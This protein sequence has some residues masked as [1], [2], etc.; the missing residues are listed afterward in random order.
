I[1]L[2]AKRARKFKEMES[3]RIVLVISG[4]NST[5]LLQKALQV[6]PW[7]CIRINAK[8][9]YEHPGETVAAFETVKSRQG[10]TIMDEIQ[11]RT[12]LII[13]TQLQVDGVQ[14]PVFGK[15]MFLLEQ[16]SSTRGL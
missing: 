10:I 15:T 16:Q 13:A 7:K 1:D 6:Y 11:S 12:G 8:F 2:I 5:E 3:C 14:G 4:I 9:A